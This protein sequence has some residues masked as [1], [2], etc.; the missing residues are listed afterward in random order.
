MTDSIRHP[1]SLGFAGGPG[2]AHC[3]LGS[4][5][6]TAK[7]R[8]RPPGKPIPMGERPADRPMAD[9]LGN[10]R[11]F[12]SQ[13]SDRGISARGTVKER[14]DAYATYGMVKPKDPT[15]FRKLKLESPTGARVQSAAPKLFTWDEAD[16]G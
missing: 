15:Y 8:A 6:N 4:M 10:G 11:C 13:D 14:G 3:S 2:G 12:S 9:Q 16:V 5:R 7:Q 1:T